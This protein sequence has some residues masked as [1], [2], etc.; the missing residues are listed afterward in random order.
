MRDASR[1][2]W[3]E[4]VIEG[5][6]EPPKGKSNKMLSVGANVSWQFKALLSMAAKRRG[7]S[8]AGYVRRALA[9][10]IATDLEMSLED[11]LKEASFPSPYGVANGQWMRD[12][13]APGDHDTGEGYGDWKNLAL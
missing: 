13:I 9:A 5:I 12:D 10:F 2:G 4:R 6:S 7:I 1:P 11:V 3:Q 8:I